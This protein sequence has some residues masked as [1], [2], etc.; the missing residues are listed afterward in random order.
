MAFGLGLLCS[1][2]FSNDVWL[3]YNGIIYY[4]EKDTGMYK[5]DIEDAMQQFGEEL[6]DYLTNLAY[7]EEYNRINGIDV[8]P[9]TKGAD[10]YFL[11][12]F[13]TDEMYADFPVIEQDFL[14]HCGDKL[15]EFSNVAW[16]DEAY[17]GIT[18]P[19]QVAYNKILRLIYNGAKIGDEYCVELIKKLYKIYF[20]KEH[21][22]LKRCKSLSVRDVL[23]LT[24]DQP[25]VDEDMAAGRILSIARF[26][27]IKLNEDCS[28]LYKVLEKKRS[29]YLNLIDKLSE[30]T[31]INQDALDFAVN[32][33]DEWIEA[34]NRDDW[35]AKP[36]KD[37]VDFTNGYFRNL[38]FVQDYDKKCIDQFAG[39]RTHLIMTLAFLKT[40]HPKKEYSFDEV[41]VY[42]HVRD[43]IIAITDLASKFDYEIGY[44]LGEEVFQEDIEESRFKPDSIEVTNKKEKEKHVELVNVA[45][46]DSANASS[47]DYLREISDLRKRLSKADAEYSALRELYKMNQQEAKNVSSLLEKYQS[48]HQELV[49]LRNYV[50]NLESEQVTSDEI[51]NDDMVKALS[52]KKILIIGGHPN[53]IS[54]MKSIFPD[55]DYIQTENF[56]TITPSITD[57]KDKVFFFHKFIS[58]AEYNHFTAYMSK[59]NIQFGY[60]SKVNIDDT[61][62]QIYKELVSKDQ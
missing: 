35:L 7:E 17:I 61:I 28:F 44:I 2:L 13:L 55:W 22:Q 11:F 50:Y 32:Q 24:E 33:V 45:P 10:F 59:N 49:K 30:G 42:S 60:L 39:G 21:N 19:L 16:Y 12:G 1:G 62:T 41:Q 52:D 20:K 18:E 48:E 38:G 36:Y 8:E 53:W 57:G 5:N 14:L 51:S 46:I 6:K 26:F 56:S 23:D 31:D 9:D 3:V 43:L 29:S 47:E 40:L 58:H 37:V 34:S 4:K 54:K 27:G 25:P 15:N